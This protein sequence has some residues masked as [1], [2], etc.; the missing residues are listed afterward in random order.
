MTTMIW[1][2]HESLRGFTCM[3]VDTRSVAIYDVGCKYDAPNLDGDDF[4]CFVLQV[5]VNPAKPWQEQC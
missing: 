1:L 4:E 3:C 2:I 5:K